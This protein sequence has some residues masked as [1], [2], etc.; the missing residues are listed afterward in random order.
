MCEKLFLVIFLFLFS[1]TILEDYLNT[2]PAE[3]MDLDPDTKAE[4]ENPVEMEIQPPRG[5]S[6]TFL[7]IVLGTS[8]FDHIPDLQ[9]ASRLSQTCKAFW[10]R[11]SLLLSGESLPVFRGLVPKMRDLAVKLRATRNT[12]SFTR[13]MR[14]TIDAQVDGDYI[15]FI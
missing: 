15:L 11:R 4:E 8:F 13:L 2:A 9:S 12:Y 6:F 5:S 10:E 14:Q 3:D 7:D 1:Y